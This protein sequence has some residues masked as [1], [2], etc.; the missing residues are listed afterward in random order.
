MRKKNVVLEKVPV[1][2]YAAEGKALARQD[3]KV[4]F[5]EGGVVPGDVVDIRLSKNKKDWAEGKATHIH[6]YSPQRVTPFCEHFGVCGGCKWQMLPYSL[7]LEYKQQQV[8]DNLQRIGHLELPAMSPILGSKYSTQYRNK[9]EF[10]FSNRA[11]LTDAEIAEDGVI[12]QRNALGFHVP[13]LFDKVL[14]IHTCHL[15]QEPVNQIRNTVKA[16]ALEHDLPFYDIRAQ[17][18]WLRNLVVRICTTGEVMVNLVIHYEDEPARK[19]LLDHLLATVPGITTIVYTINPKKNDSIF[20]LEPRIYFGKGYVEEK[21]EDFVFKIGPKSFFQTNTY[22]GVTLYQV[23]RDFAGLTGTEIVYDLYCG[24]GSIG[25]FV[26][27]KAAKVIGI[28]LI[29]EAIDDA[30]ENATANQ[31]Q[32][33]EFFAGDVVDICDDAF[34]AQHGQPGVVITDPPRAGMHEKLVE[35]LLQIAAPK[36]VY[37]SCNPATQARDLAL[38]SKMYTVK[39]VQPVDMFPHTHHIENVVLLEKKLLAS[40]K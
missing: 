37:V 13:K 14:D 30:R 22:Q 17:Q 5:I 27:R 9:L 34:F 24:T 28:E 26:S 33:A 35:K 16:Y 20:D 36:I 2:A 40:E 8:V 12:P 18:G 19:A 11:Y 10:T 38:L 21:L 31:V 7:Q 25:I 32:N 3:G 6:T 15:Q 1:T 23:T 4:I 29:K 39:K